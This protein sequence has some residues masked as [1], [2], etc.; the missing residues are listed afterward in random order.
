MERHLPIVDIAGTE[1]Y[2]DVLRDEL[3]QKINPQNRISFDE[4]KENEN[5]YSFVYDVQA[6]NIPPVNT[7][8]EKEGKYLW[9]TL[10]ALMELDPEGISRK[11]GIPLEALSPNFPD[12]N[13][14][15]IARL[16]P[17]RPSGENKQ[18]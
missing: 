4:L 17:F 11:Y 2:V 3:R 12:A 7:D 14:K 18:K 9:V 8:E 5:G 16:Q 15:V 10:P 1:F 6:K 13:N